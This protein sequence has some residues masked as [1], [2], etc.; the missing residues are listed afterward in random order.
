MPMRCSAT[1]ASEGNG[2]PPAVAIKGTTILAGSEAVKVTALTGTR[3]TGSAL[4]KTLTAA[5]ANGT[6]TIT[7]ATKINQKI[8]DNNQVNNSSSSSSRTLMNFRG[9]RRS[10]SGTSL[11][12][13]NRR[14]SK[15]HPGKECSLTV[16]THCP[17]SFKS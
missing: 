5:E 2:K 4:D 16:K 17:G 6:V 9:R 1:R 14:A 7:T 12:S 11:G 15:D 8:K 3:M 13:L 10:S